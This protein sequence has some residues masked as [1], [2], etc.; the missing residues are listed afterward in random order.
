M[1]VEF[2]VLK[3]FT[4]DEVCFWTNWGYDNTCRFFLGNFWMDY[5]S[6]SYSFTVEFGNFSITIPIISFSL[7]LSIK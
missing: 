2:R 6:I 4:I 1:F 7:A 3:I 5:V